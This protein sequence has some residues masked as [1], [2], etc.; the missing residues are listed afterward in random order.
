[1]PLCTTICTVRIWAITQGAICIYKIY[2]M[3]PGILTV[4]ARLLSRMLRGHMQ[5]TNTFDVA[6]NIPLFI[7]PEG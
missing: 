5:P 4:A 1:M 3:I 7:N 2:R 6:H